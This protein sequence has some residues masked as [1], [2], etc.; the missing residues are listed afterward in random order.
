[1]LI[2]WT[3][4]DLEFHLAELAKEP[5][6]CSKGGWTGRRGRVHRALGASIDRGLTVAKAA[7]IN[8]R[9]LIAVH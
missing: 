5:R 1:M 9:R 6:S 8:P 2:R 4:A 3:C 7:G